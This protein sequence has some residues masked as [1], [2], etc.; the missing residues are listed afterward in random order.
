MIGRR[1][2]CALSRC[3]KNKLMRRVFTALAALSIAASVLPVAAE[4]QTL[5]LI[6]I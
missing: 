5:S 1:S 3:R 2:S 4:A 6:H